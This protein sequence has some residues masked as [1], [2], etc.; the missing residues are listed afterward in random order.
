MVAHLTLR[1]NGVQQE[2]RFVEGMW[3]H[4]K[5]CQIR[6]FFSR[7]IPFLHHAC[8]TY[9]EQPSN[10]KTMVIHRLRIRVEI[11]QIRINPHLIKKDADPT[12]EN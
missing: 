3:L 10:I 5:S 1:T 12:L 9:S 11:D 6:F 4:R 7:K 8:A 2:F